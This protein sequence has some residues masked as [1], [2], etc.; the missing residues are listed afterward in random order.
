[1]AF[2]S[3]PTTNA[4]S[5]RTARGSRLARRTRRRRCFRS[6]WRARHLVLA[7]HAA[8]PVHPHPNAARKLRT[9]DA[10]S[11]VSRGKNVSDDR[12]GVL[13]AGS[14]SERLLRAPRARDHEAPVPKATE[15]P[16]MGLTSTKN[17]IAANAI[18][19]ILAKP[20]PLRG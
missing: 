4:S 15:R 6:P 18:E 12:F 7:L 10:S 17:F 8:D 1:M 13:W 16:L 3:R 5:A 14:D 19:N 9:L 2:P 11:H 20:P